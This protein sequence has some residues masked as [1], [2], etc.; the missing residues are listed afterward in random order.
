MTKINS[1]KNKNK[2]DLMRGYIEGY[3]GRL[4]TWDE[5]GLILNHLSQLGMG[6]YLYAPK[7]DPC[8]RFDWRQ[9]YDQD[10]MTRFQSFCTEAKA[11]HVNVIAGI[12]PGI[13]FDFGHLNS[14][15]DG[16]G[17]DWHCLIKKC[18]ALIAA[19]ADQVA[20]LLDDIQPDFDEKSG[21]F[22]NEAEAHAT[23]ANALNHALS[24]VMEKPIILTP[25]IYADEMMGHDLMASGAN[26]DMYWPQLAETLDQQIMLLVCGKNVVSHDTSLEDT[27]MAKAGIPAERAII[28][29]NLYAHD[30]CPRRLFLGLW[31]GRHDDQHILLNPT[32]MPHTDM[33]LLSFMDAGDDAEGWRQAL[34]KHGV[35]EAFLQ[36]A[37]FFNLPPRGEDDPS[38]SLDEEKMLAA[39]DLMLWQ[40]KSPVQREWYPYLMGLR[41]DILL[42]TGQMN[43]LRVR[44][45]L[46]PLLWSH[47]SDEDV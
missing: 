10:W 36:I 41:Q 38:P 35:P 34:R 46:P 13:D 32:G 44:K 27:A 30:Y 2:P 42:K 5:R 26:D 21:A 7:E 25:R 39:L 19:G 23:L 18:R 22:T 4:L 45:S 15:H 8:H 16:G 47:E 37:E 3:Y 12:A 28:W 40:W 20:L 31:Q 6:Y 11:S 1:T 33:V 9:D 17:H 29:D 24:D 14:D 43:K